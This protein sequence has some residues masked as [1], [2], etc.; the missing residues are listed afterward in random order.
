MTDKK[1]EFQPGDMQLGPADR[2]QR[3]KV[4]CTQRGTGDP[5]PHFFT[6]REMAEAWVNSDDAKGYEGI[7]IE[8]RLGT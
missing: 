8:D 6:T 7:R 4:H 5:R 1:I 2:G 3:F